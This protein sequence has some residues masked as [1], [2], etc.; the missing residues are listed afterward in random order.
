MATLVR[1]LRGLLAN[2]VDG[3][4]MSSPDSVCQTNGEVN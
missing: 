4:A 1:E 3:G 2:G